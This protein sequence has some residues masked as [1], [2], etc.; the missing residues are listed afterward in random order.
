MGNCCCP[1][2]DATEGV[3]SAFKLLADS[4]EGNKELYFSDQRKKPPND[5]EGYPPSMIPPFL[6]GDEQVDFFLPYQDM[7]H[8]RQQLACSLIRCVDNISDRDKWT[9]VH[10]HSFDI[11][12]SKPVIILC[13]GFMSWRNQ[14]LLSFLAA[15]LTR[16]LQC[17]T[18][19]FDFAG[20][21]HSTG[22]WHYG[23]YDGEARDLD[24]VIK[25]VQNSMKCRVCCVVGHSKGSAS[26]LRCACKQEQGPHMERIPCFVNLSGRFSV[27]N[28]YAVHSR[29]TN[30]QESALS[31]NGKFLLETR[32]QRRFEVTK[33][34]I[35]ERSRLDSSLVRQIQNS[36]VLT[37]HGDSDSVV[38]VS[39]AYRFSKNIPKHELC[40][41]EGADHNF[42]G[43]RH[44]D[45]LA[46]T[47][48]KFVSAMD[49]RET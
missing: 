2:S 46:L 3:P 18:L 13:H 20:N 37:I 41:I 25:F 7:S 48:S 11:D 49:S 26:V 32:G 21:G 34:D 40:I 22:T 31:L 24:H 36:H 16:K 43:L 15:N 27:P 6:T 39:N 47:T 9:T 35:E 23:N 33:K 19:R 29:F 1:G 14:M 44:M 10:G 45:D 12:S 28:E 38:D 8:Q 42:N 30:D 5:C 17:H 4:K